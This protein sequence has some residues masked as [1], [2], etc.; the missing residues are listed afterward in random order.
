MAHPITTRVLHTMDDFAGIV[1]LQQQIWG[2]AREDTVSPYIMNAISHNG[3]SILVAEIDDIMVGFCLGF[4]SK[5]DTS[6]IFW[7]HMAGVLPDFQGH[8]IGYML[9]QAQR[10]W[11][12]ENGYDTISWTFDPLQRGNA[13]FN[14]KYLGVIAS[15]Y[16][17]NLY[18]EMTDAINVGLAS[19]RLEARWLLH[20]SHVVT[21]SNGQVPMD[22]S[23][24][25]SDD[26]FLVQFTNKLIIRDT[27]LSLD[28]Y[29]IEIPYHISTLKKS[30][31]TKAIQWQL[32]VRQVMLT[33][34]NQGYIACNFIQRDERCW[35]V[36]RKKSSERL[37]H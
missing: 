32:A 31:K 12:I 7:S 1:E 17:I 26:V 24:A 30:N 33:A 34:F 35:Y 13:N 21:L 29:C 8:Q 3:G 2:M 25:L 5:R 16:H 10:R 23:K 28:N 18:G 6:I 4:A 19:D 11:A 15:E 9:K 27:S 14:F 37:S 20:D 22:S 36:L